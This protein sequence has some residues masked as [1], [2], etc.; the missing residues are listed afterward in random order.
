MTWNRNL[1]RQVEDLLL[2]SAIGFTTQELVDKLHLNPRERDAVVAFLKDSES[3]K[4]NRLR[5][6]VPVRAGTYSPE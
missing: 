5:R 6:W 3:F 4:K 1:Q 2:G